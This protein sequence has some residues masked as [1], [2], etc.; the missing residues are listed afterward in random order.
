MSEAGGEARGAGAGELGGGH[1]AAVE[2]AEGGVGAIV[3]L[4]PEPCDRSAAGITRRTPA[5]RRRAL[6]PMTAARGPGT[7]SANPAT[8]ATAAG[9]SPGSPSG[10]RTSIV[11]D[12]VGQGGGERHPGWPGAGGGVVAQL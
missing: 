1:G 11:H 5:T 7:A 8:G 10:W 4:G 12:R 6:P 9:T 2:E 3:T